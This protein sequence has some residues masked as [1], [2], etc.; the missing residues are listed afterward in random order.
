MLRL[1]RP[2]MRRSCPEIE[3]HERGRPQGF[4]RRH[5]RLLKHFEIVVQAE[6]RR[7]VFPKGQP[8]NAGYRLG[9]SYPWPRKRGQSVVL[10]VF[11]FYSGAS[12][13]SFLLNHTIPG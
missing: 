2:R 4:H 7:G 12:T 3:P 6:I 5:P 8:A 1:H 11:N 13:L 10:N 9:T